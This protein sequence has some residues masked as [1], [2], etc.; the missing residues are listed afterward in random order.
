VSDGHVLQ[1]FMQS[2]CNYEGL[3]S[4]KIR[5]LNFNYSVHLDHLFTMD[6]CEWRLYWYV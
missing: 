2:S 1:E 4:H 6:F 5:F 3:W